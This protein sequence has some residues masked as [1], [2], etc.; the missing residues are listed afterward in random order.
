MNSTARMSKRLTDESAACPCARYLTGI[1][2]HI[3]MRVNKRLMTL[4]QRIIADII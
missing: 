3:D 1:T 4:I 2:F